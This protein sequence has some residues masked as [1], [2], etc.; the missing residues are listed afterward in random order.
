[1]CMPKLFCLHMV[2]VLF[3]HEHIHIG[4]SDE[5]QNMGQ[6]NGVM[7]VGWK[8]GVLWHGARVVIYWS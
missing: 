7:H 2:L 3:S 8:F 1:M 6:Y 5:K 4:N